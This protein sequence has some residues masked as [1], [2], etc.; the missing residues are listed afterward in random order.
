[1]KGMQLIGNGDAYWELGRTFLGFFE[2]TLKQIITK[3]GFDI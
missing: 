1:V 2:E 3:V